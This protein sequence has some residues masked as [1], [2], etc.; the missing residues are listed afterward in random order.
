[1]GCFV[2]FSDSPPYPSKAIIP[3]QTETRFIQEQHPMPFND[4]AAEC[5]ITETVAVPHLCSSC[6]QRAFD[7]YERWLATVFDGTPRS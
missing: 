2:A 3:P 6:L 5:K 4:P 7:S 1:M